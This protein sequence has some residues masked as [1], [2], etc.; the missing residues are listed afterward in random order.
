M[1]IGLGVTFK[2]A[3]LR[4]GIGSASS[5]PVYVY[6]RLNL[7]WINQAPINLLR[8]VISHGVDKFVSQNARPK[9]DH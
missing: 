8:V 5:P 1:A 2:T 7:F 4:L 3:C 9:I 6:I